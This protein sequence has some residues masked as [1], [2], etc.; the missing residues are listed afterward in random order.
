M[1]SG[2]TNPENDS[3]VFLH[4]KS[5]YSSQSFHVSTD[6]FCHNLD[7]VRTTDVLFKD[8]E[9]SFIGFGDVGKFG[10]GVKENNRSTSEVI[11]LY[12]ILGKNMTS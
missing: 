5:Y 3:V 2:R 1:I 12:R 11:L 7:A 9:K 6:T 8:S 4:R 10:K